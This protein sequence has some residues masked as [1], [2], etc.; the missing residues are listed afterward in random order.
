MLQGLLHYDDTSGAAFHGNAQGENVTYDRKGVQVRNGN[1]TSQVFA[2]PELIEVSQLKLRALNGIVNGDLRFVNLRSMAFRGSVSA[3]DVRS[4]VKLVVSK[5][6]PFTASVAGPVTLDTQLGDVLRN[7]VITADVQVI[8][9]PNQWSPAGRVALAYRQSSNALVFN[10]CD[11]AFPQSAVSLA[12]QLNSVMQ[13]E[14]NTRSLRD[15]QPLFAWVGMTLPKSLRLDGPQSEAK[16]KGQVVGTIDQPSV[17]GN[18]HV[19]NFRLEDHHW[20]AA[21]ADFAASS[22][23]LQVMNAS[24]KQAGSGIRLSGQI[25]LRDW[26]V[27]EDSALAVQGTLNTADLASVVHSFARTSADLKGGGGSA[28]LNL[29]GTLQNLN[30]T[31]GIALHNLRAYGETLDQFHAAVAFSGNK[32]S[33]T[34]AR[35]R[36]GTAATTFRAEYERRAGTWD[37]GILHVRADTNGFALDTLSLVR[38]HVHGLTARSELH[39]EGDFRVTHREVEPLSV[40]GTL[41]LRDITVATVRRGD[42]TLNARTEGDL[43][44]VGIA[45]NLEGSPVSGNL[46]AHF[47]GEDIGS[48]EMRFGK[49]SLATALALV[50]PMSA[51]RPGWDG[52]FGGQLTFRGP[53]RSW[54]LI[55]SKL[56]LDG[57]QVRTTGA[58]PG[59]VAADN[60][61]L[62]NQGP[63]IVEGKGSDITIRQLEM[64]TRDTRFAVTGSINLASGRVDLHSD[65]SVDARIL[66]LVYPD[67]QIAGVAAVSLGIT[68]VPEK[69]AYSGSIRVKNA[70]LFAPDL[71]NGLS[72][73]NGTLRFD[74]NRAVLEDVTS[75][76]GGGTVRLTG[77]ISFAPN[78]PLSYNVE[79]QASRVRFRYL[80]ASVTGDA[81]LRMTGTTKNGL[82]A[83][84]LSLSRIVL[85]PGADLANALASA[86]TPSAT[87]INEQDFITGLGLDVHIQSSPDLQVLTSLSQD[88]QA[89]IDLHLRGTREHPALLGHISANQ[90]EVNVFGTRYALSRGNITFINPVRIDPVL[91]LDLQ[92]ETRGITVDVVITGTLNKL[93][94]N[95]RSDP[96]LQAKDIL[97]LLTVGQTPTFA[98]EASNSRVQADT[99]ALQAGAST[100]LGQAISPASNRL[101]KLF[102]ITNVKIDPFVQNV[103]SSRQARL[104]LEQQISRNITVTYVTNLAQTS[105]QIFRFEWAFNPQY[106]VVAVRDDNGEFGVDIQYKKRFK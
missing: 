106:S 77:V 73:I 41:A 24:V 53:L 68:G 9:Q 42:L 66:Q 99:T 69:P 82:L 71:T 40:N 92:T 22:S 6:L 89:D 78:E 14:A 95:Y 81:S 91:D 84:D 3:I 44:T 94:M 21:D 5:P 70:S 61:V 30:G 55:D 98:P 43:L 56:V 87:P 64:S 20:D 62:T 45:G 58:L 96:P 32:A 35:L 11:L 27:E 7:T 52:S 57:V 33:I 63:V 48:G 102:G 65:G 19:R 80:R 51:N 67:L 13:V 16:F 25:T 76:T 37:S 49:I 34:S 15:I 4:F 54:N 93:S 104:T 60:F 74:R 88:V 36:S 26:S 100:V 29:A 72:A 23:Q 17:T 39:A 85:E 86:A 105:E 10:S 8:P 31:G 50:S 38:E 47:T 2:T 12:G 46:H 103:Y 101:S 83:G 79:A 1:F 18:V 75:E 90:G 59:G 28:S 97:A